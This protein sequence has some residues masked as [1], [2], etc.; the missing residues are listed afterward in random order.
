MKKLSVIAALVLVGAFVFAA[1][2]A[3]K[4]AAPAAP[5]AAPAATAAAAPA[6]PAAPAVTTLEGTI[7]KVIVAN[8]AKKTSDEISVVGAD[9][10][11]VLIGVKA[12]AVITG[13]DGKALAF[14]KLAAKE[15]VKVEYTLKGKLAEASSITVE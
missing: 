8:K 5:A 11:A 7:A 1:D 3:T 4:P 6:A 12:G 13:A 15:K 2:N 10:K 14:A 9:G